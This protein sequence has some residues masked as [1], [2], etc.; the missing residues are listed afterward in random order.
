MPGERQEGATGGEQDERLDDSDEPTFD[1]TRRGVMRAGGGLAVA[2]FVGDT[3]FEDDG[4]DLEAAQEVEISAQGLEYFTIEQARV[5]HDL[6]GRIYPSDDN[7]PG[8]PEAGVVYFVDEQMNSAWGR[9]DR[10]YMDPPF[11]GKQPT[12]SFEEEAQDPSET[13]VEVSFGD[14]EPAATQGWQY[15]ATPE[16]A[17]SDGIEAVEEYAQSEYDDAFVDLD[18]DQQDEIVQALQDGEVDT[19]EDKAIDSEGF[20]LLA[21]QNTLEGMFADPMY[22]GNRE[23][24]GWRLKNFPGTPGALGSYRNQIA[25]GEYIEVGSDDFRKMADDVESLG[26][27]G[28]GGSVDLGGENETDNTTAGNS[29]ASDSRGHSHVHAASEGDFPKVVDKEAARGNAD[30]RDDDEDEGGES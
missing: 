19:F 7:G 4:F 14:Q 6:T 3:W 28:N 29:S 5:V 17:W 26:L 16:T 15:T 10:W 2:G 18:G 1:F 11:A 12:P 8:A 21:Y 30:G 27:N 25:E 20:F 24:I 22:G 9:G 23:M 13:D